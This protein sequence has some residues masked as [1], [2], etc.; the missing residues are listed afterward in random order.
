MLDHAA[1]HEAPRDA[2]PVY[3]EL[4]ES[5][6]QFAQAAA[7][8][9]DVFTLQ[10][11]ARVQSVTT[12]S[13]LPALE[14][15]VEAGLIRFTGDRLAF[16][17]PDVRQALH[18]RIPA[19]VRR[20]LL[21][22]APAARPAGQPATE[23]HATPDA[24]V[25]ALF[26][27]H[28]NPSGPLDPRTAEAA[29]LALAEILSPTGDPASAQAEAS[30]VL[31]LFG[32]DEQGRRERARAMV[33]AGGPGAVPVVAAVVLS[34]LEWA[35]G[36]LDEALRCGREALAGDHAVLP[37]GWRPYP[38]L[39]LAVK[40]TQLG[41]F[42]EAEAALTRTSEL[43]ERLGHQRARAEAAVV[44]GRLLLGAGRTEAAEAE[45]SSG[46]SLAQR[47]H[48]RLPASQGLSL[49]SLL[50]LARGQRGEAADQVW[51]ARMELVAQPGS[52]LSL[53]HTWADFQVATAGMDARGAVGLLVERYPDLLTR[54]SLFVRDPAAAARLV[55]LSL[56]AEE[57]SLAAAVT[58][59]VERL[60][61][62]NPAHPGLAAA[63]THA[64]GL[65]YEDPDA[66]E[67]AAT[68]HRAPWAAAAASEDLGTLLLGRPG[69][70]TGAA[71]RHLRA[72]AERYHAIG[73]HA[74][75]ARLEALLRESAQGRQ[76]P[77]DAEPAARPERA[78]APAGS[79]LTAAEQRIARLVA[80]GLTNKQVATRVSCSPHTVNYHLR[81]IFR[82]LGVAS[83][84]ELARLLG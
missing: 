47:T 16:R 24:L 62:R 21:R 39:A 70:D 50:S 27:S 58:R 38:S 73:A 57:N 46:V 30:R 11:I 61:E 59:R 53:R 33:R 78:D 43:A 52:F 84:V 49:L 37:P 45:I 42:A 76:R 75:V 79:A 31:S 1:P 23:A 69:S 35:A 12:L 32:P 13:M 17:S 25:S 4:S 44:R 5:A 48:A 15:T 51:R 67:H 81:Q 20:T 72:A 10:E 74:A 40:L 9:G 18:A 63:A 55:R 8:V 29:H 36:H 80:Q 19:P 3:G 22:G 14:E 83:R 77:A 56:A 7:L 28:D 82:K 34:N 2:A 41:R 66:L 64:R 60:A 71:R 6:W 26:L 54:P 65:L 68:E